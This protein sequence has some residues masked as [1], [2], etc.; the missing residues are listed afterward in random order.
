[1]DFEKIV[2]K[3]QSVNSRDAIVN[4][5]IRHPDAMPDFMRTFFHSDLIITQ[6]L[7]WSLSYIA[8][9]QPQLLVPFLDQLMGLIRDKDKHVAV[10]RNVLRA[11][12]YLHIPQRLESAVYEQCIQALM[13]AKEPVAVK[14][15]SI[16]ILVRICKLYPELS[17]EVLSAIQLNDTVTS[18]GFVN[19]SQKAIRTLAKHK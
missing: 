8:E 4:H 16:Q 1:M 13:D 18:P 10:R 11:F 6:R 9:K 19:C 14:C 17:E 3:G 5:L 12:I 7:A 2:A 15:F